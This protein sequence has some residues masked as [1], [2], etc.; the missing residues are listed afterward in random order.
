MVRISASTLLHAPGRIPFICVWICNGSLG[1]AEF[2][3][4]HEWRGFLP[5]IIRI[6]TKTAGITVFTQFV[7]P[8]TAD[9]ADGAWKAYYERWN[10]ATRAKLPADQ[11]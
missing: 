4:L 3:K 6:A 5:N 8:V 9:E 7:T 11:L 1:R 10:A 2:G